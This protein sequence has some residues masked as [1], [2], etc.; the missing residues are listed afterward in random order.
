MNNTQSKGE[1]LT[2]NIFYCVL[3]FIWYKT[4]ILRSMPNQTRANSVLVLVI[5]IGLSLAVGIPA[6]WK[7]HRNNFSVFANIA[8][9][10]GLYNLIT[11]YKT[12]PVLCTVITV[13]SLLL[14]LVYFCVILSRKIRNPEYSSEI[15]RKRIF[16]C[17]RGTR[18]IVTVGLMLI[19]VFLGA[20]ALLGNSL[21]HPKKTAAVPTDNV[22]ASESADDT[23]IYKF[24]KNTWAN[25]TAKQKVTAMQEVADMQAQVLGI[26]HELNISLK[27][28]EDGLY[29]TYTDTDHT[30]SINIDITDD[31]YEVLETLFHEAYHA[32]QHRLCDA[33]DTLDEEYKSLDVFYNVR[34][35][36]E[37]FADYTSGDEDF[38]E[39]YC[40]K[41]ET[42]A[43]D[44]AETNI[45]I[46]KELIA[47]HM[48][49]IN[50][51]VAE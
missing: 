39:Y 32:Y 17:L 25:L 34:Y 10:F 22:A 15:I 7:K 49:T 42:V 46:A 37:E 36:K 4:S 5:M 9:P 20:N 44:Y 29:G 30:I 41:C 21:I 47:Y 3:S 24:D 2:N 16:H 18:S 33:Y 48:D 26:N 35:Y 43:R 45:D 28:L 19:V 13:V 38:S 50:P 12:L 31:S 11:Y 8:L 51:T 14:S 6:G 40:Q 23:C 1:Y 27:P